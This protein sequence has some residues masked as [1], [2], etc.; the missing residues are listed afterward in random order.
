MRIVI[1]DFLESL[2]GNEG[3]A[4]DASEQNGVVVAL[5]SLI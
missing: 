5:A 4:T 3:E 2:I 1:L